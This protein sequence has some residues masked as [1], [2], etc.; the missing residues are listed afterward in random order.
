M[1]E[2]KETNPFKPASHSFLGGEVAELQELIKGIHVALELA[3]H[4]LA[5]LETR[6]EA[7]YSRHN[8]YPPSLR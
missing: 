7:V 6:V 3:T 5:L 8:E 1:T 4:H 2:K